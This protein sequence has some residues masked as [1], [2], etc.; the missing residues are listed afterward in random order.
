MAST[1][2]GGALES[3]TAWEDAGA[4]WRLLVVDD[5]RAVVQLCTCTGE[6]VDRLESEDPDL[7]AHVRDHPASRR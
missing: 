6:P 4:T 5:V 2:R 1:P 7:V 3:L